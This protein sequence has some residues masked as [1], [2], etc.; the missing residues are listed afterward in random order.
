VSQS[1]DPA[2]SGAGISNEARRTPEP[3][4]VSADVGRAGPTQLLTPQAQRLVALAIPA[5]VVGVGTSIVLELVSGVAG[6]LEH[7]LWSDI[8]ATLGIDPNGAP[9]IF[10][11]LTLTGLAVGLVIAYAPGHAG[12]DPAT[13]GLVAP[14]LPVSALPGMVLAIVLVLAGGVSLGP[15]YPI[16]S[17]NIA[18]A[19]F[20]GARAI[21]R[22]PGRAWVALAFAGTIGAMFGTPVAAALLLSESLSA[23]DEPLWDRLFAPLVAA[24]AGAQTTL[25]L[26]GET[27]SLAVP[28]YPGMQLGD[29]LS[30]CIVAVA[31]ATVAM[32]AVYAFPLSHGAFSRFRNPVLITVAG[33]VLLGVLGVI[34]GPITLFKG[35]D[36][37]KELTKDASS[38]SAGALGA[39]ALIKLAALVVAA[40]SRFRG[41]RIF[42]AVFVGVAFGLFAS[43]LVPAVPLPIGVSTGVLGVLLATT[44]SGWMAIFM[45]IALVPDVQLLPVICIAALPAWL[46][47]TGRPIMQV[48]P[49]PGAHVEPA[50][51][52]A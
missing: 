41:G 32:V 19:A 35:L 1:S 21:G 3:G 11:L 28:D 22:I 45:G 33:G 10:G 6:V 15:E 16:M 5:A 48:A 14:V 13:E 42:P 31:A 30:A 49:E 43:T 46:I 47:V 25:L 50:P 52:S 12:D 20:L 44:R 51:A 38:Y 4:D 26:G 8:P 9:W 39:I 34:G 37:M 18:L 2:P 40:T 24:A 27:F 7:W 17:I 29:I 36:Q 23:S